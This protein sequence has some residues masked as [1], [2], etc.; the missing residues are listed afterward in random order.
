MLRYDII[1]EGNII[2]AEGSGPISNQDLAEFFSE[3]FQNPQFTP[4]TRVFFDASRLEAGNLGEMGKGE[5]GLSLS[6]A[7][8]AVRIAIFVPRGDQFAMAEHWLR[9]HPGIERHVHLFS[10]LNIAQLW[11]GIPVFVV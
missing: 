7:Y 5:P 3:I 8:P 11:L 10:D 2:T 6:S 9:L 4:D 1:P